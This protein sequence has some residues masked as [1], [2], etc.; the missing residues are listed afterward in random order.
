LAEGILSAMRMAAAAALVAFGLVGAGSAPGIGITIT[1]GQCSGGGTSFCF[2]PEAAAVQTGVPVTWTDQSGV[3][4]EVV[5]CT[6]SACLG[7]PV[8]TGTQ[9]FDVFVAADGHAAFTF[10]RIGTYYY[11]CSIH[12]YASMH[13]SII[14]TQAATPTPTPTPVPTARPTPRPTPRATPAPTVKP[15]SATP[16]VGGTASATPTASALPT[17]TESTVTAP[18]AVPSAGISPSPS[19]SSPHATAIVTPGGSPA[20][21]VAIVVILLAAASATGYLARRRRNR[22]AG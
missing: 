8:S 22:R 3:A 7:S 19:P 13:G 11:Y 2:N 5:S 4:H 16:T 18:S 15:A 9:T 17:P 21:A 14:V 12:G 6:P 20:I 10:S 1:S